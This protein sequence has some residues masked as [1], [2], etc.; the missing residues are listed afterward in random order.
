MR[1]VDGSV[2]CEPAEEG[3]L[4]QKGAPTSKLYSGPGETTETPLFYVRRLFPALARPSSFASMQKLRLR[5]TL[6]RLFRHAAHNGE[7]GISGP[8]VGGQFLSR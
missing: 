1:I 8:I 2:R 3:K 5:F 6:I 4:P 7:E